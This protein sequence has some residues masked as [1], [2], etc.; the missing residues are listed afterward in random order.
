MNVDVAKSISLSY[1]NWSFHHTPGQKLETTHLTIKG[2]S[3]YCREIKHDSGTVVLRFRIVLGLN[4]RDLVGTT[5][6]NSLVTNKILYLYEFVS[7]V[8]TGCLKRSGDQDS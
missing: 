5:N 6:A 3:F 4:F 8:K 1:C 2:N 7:L